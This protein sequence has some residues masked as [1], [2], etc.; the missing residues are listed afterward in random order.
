M[1]GTDY[2]YTLAMWIRPSSSKF[3]E[4]NQNLF[5]LEN[6]MICKFS[7]SKL[8]CGGTSLS[9]QASIDTSAIPEGKWTHL[10]FAG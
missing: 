6:D 3:K 10:V 5:K 4:S 2:S 7:N 9:N 8:S 1:L